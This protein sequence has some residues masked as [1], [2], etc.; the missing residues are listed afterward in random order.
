MMRNMSAVFWKDERKQ[1]L[2]KVH[3]PH[4]SLM[5]THM[6]VANSAWLVLAAE[7]RMQNVNQLLALAE[8]CA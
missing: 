3:V 5:V 7:F 8:S 2:L 4:P 6:Y 1:I